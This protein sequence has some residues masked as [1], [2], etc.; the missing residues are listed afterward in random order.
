M[1]LNL[2]CIRAILL[3]VEKCDYNESIPIEI[4]EK[5]LPT[6][7]NQ[8]IRYN[9]L[10]LYEAGYISAICVHVDNSTLPYIHEII[11]ITYPGHEFL[12][13]IRKEENWEKTKEIG[14]KIGSFGLRMAGTIAEGVASAYFKQVLGVP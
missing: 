7:Y 11:D 1:K 9:C 13:S 4:L 5:R 12:A 8:D 2:D 3:E 10:K 14:E 6:Y